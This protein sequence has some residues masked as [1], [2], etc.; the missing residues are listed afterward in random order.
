[1]KAKIRGTEIYFDIAGMQLAP[2]GKSLIE[3]PVLFLIHGGPGG[4]HVNYKFHSIKLQEYAQLVFIDLRGCGWSKKTKAS[5]YTLENNIE[6][7][8]A[9]RKYLGLNRISVLGASYGGMVAQG[10]AIRYSKHIDKLI[11]AVT[12]PSYHFMEEARKYIDQHGTYKQIAYCEK[13][14]WKGKFKSDKQ[15]NDYFKLTDSL[16]FYRNRKNRI[17]PS[18]KKLTSAEF[19]KFSTFSHEALNAGFGGF[20]HHFN[21]IPRLKK[22]TC[23]TLILAGQHDW[24]CRPDQSK[25]MAKH[26]PNAK[27]KI[28]ANCGHAIATDANKKYIAEVGRFLLTKAKSKRD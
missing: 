8:E 19:K 28:F 14:L 23:P 20:L 3:K 6:D 21:F 12:A 7:I 10:Y 18:F 4:N 16:Y 17:R 22:I 15:I 24:I 27:L 1:M 13:Y 26:I 11:L 5:D 25:I 2:Q 9:L